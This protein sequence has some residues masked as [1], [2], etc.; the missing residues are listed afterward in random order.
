[1]PPFQKKN[2]LKKKDKEK[3]TK[4]NFWSDIIILL[5]IK[6]SKV[7]LNIKTNKQLFQK[8]KEKIEKNLF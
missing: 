2:K 3:L 4:N 6:I 1:M 8:F 7:D 5:S